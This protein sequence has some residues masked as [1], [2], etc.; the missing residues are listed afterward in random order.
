MLK[1]SGNQNRDI[2]IDP[3]LLTDFANCKYKATQRI[4][5]LFI[6]AL[7]EIDNFQKCQREK[8]KERWF[9]AINDEY[10]AFNGTISS[11]A[12]LR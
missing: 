8:M 5:R 3:E 7:S 6:N 2:V 11:F 4:D 10:L 12:D 1:E 9:P